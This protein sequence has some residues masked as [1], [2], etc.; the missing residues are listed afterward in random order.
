MDT[1]APEIRAILSG[2]L[3][4]STVFQDKPTPGQQVQD[5]RWADA[6]NLPTSKDII[7]S[8][9][10]S[11]VRPT[12]LTQERATVVESSS[13]DKG[14]SSPTT[15][16]S[17]KMWLNRKQR[18]VY[19]MGYVALKWAWDRFQ[20]YMEEFNWRE[21]VENIWKQSVVLLTDLINKIIKVAHLLNSL[22]FLTNGLFPQLLPRLLKMRMMPNSPFPFYPSPAY[23][24]MN[25]Q[26]LWDSFLVSVVLVSWLT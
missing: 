22:Q 24:I 6:E 3:T 5:L 11:Q 15:S 16:G 2:M 9:A 10:R 8:Y 26:L 13:L 14:H 18:Y 19:S 17:E 12:Q 21:D 1:F 20:R 7:D 23:D 4:F 25:R